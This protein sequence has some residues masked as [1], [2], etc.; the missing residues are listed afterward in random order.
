LRLPPPSTFTLPS[1]PH[2]V[3]PTSTSA[4][5]SLSRRRRTATPPRFL[6]SIIN[7]TLEGLPPSQPTE[8]TTPRLGSG[9][10]PT[11]RPSSLGAPPE[12]APSPTLPWGTTS[13]D[14]LL[15]PIHPRHEP[16]HRPT[17][18]APAQ[19]STEAPS[20][21]SAARETLLD[22]PLP[23]MPD[24]LSNDPFH[25]PG[26][27]E[28][29]TRWRLFAERGGQW[30][31]PRESFRFIPFS[32]S[33]R[34]V[35][36]IEF[37]RSPH[38]RPRATPNRDFETSLARRLRQQRAEEDIASRPARQNAPDYQSEVVGTGDLPIV[39]SSQ[40]FAL[41]QARCESSPSTF[42]TSHA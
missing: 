1:N 30:R 14:N 25:S 12:A 23:T 22:T 33:D 19:P 13:A 32:D 7:A 39:V 40:Q 26:A 15:G 11:S 28:A 29:S 6:M 38:P 21:L 4:P 34:T 37:N 20:P 5:S 27:E 36:Q 2:T 18:E 8:P 35:W 42:P 3:H 31:P 17:H 16:E 9:A 10:N 24:M 41:T